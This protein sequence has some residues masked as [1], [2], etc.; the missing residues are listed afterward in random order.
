V[1]ISMAAID[2]LLTNE[3]HILHGAVETNRQVHWEILQRQGDLMA[4][5]SD[6]GL[7]EA[8]ALHEAARK[9][10]QADLI[11]A[12]HALVNTLSELMKTR[13]VTR[14]KQVRAL[15]NCW[16]AL[17]DA[18]FNWRLNSKLQSVNQWNSALKFGKLSKGLTAG[19]GLAGVTM[20]LVAGFA[21]PSPE[22]IMLE[23]IGKVKQMIFELGND[24]HGRFD[25]VD[26]SLNSIQTTLNETLNLVNEV[27][28]DVRQARQGLLEVQLDLHRLERQLFTSFTEQQRHNLKL[29][30]NSALYYENFNPSPMDWTDYSQSPNYEN[31]FYTYAT[32]FAANSISSPSSFLADDLADPNLQQQ[33]AARPLSANLNYLKAV[34]YSRTGQAVFGPQQPVLPNPQD[35]FVSAHTYLQLALENPGHFRNKGMRLPPLIAR[36]QELRNFFR[37]LTLG[38]S[39]TSVNRDLY[40]AL[41]VHYVNKLGNFVNQ[42]HTTEQAYAD[43]HLDH[44]PV[45]TWRDWA[46]AAPRVTVAGTG[47]RPLPLSAQ[48]VT[49][50]A[51][52]GYHNLALT[53]DGTVVGWGDD[54]AGQMTIPADVTQVTALAAGLYHSLALRS[55]DQVIAWGANDYGEGRQPADA[56]N[57]LAIAAG[58]YHNLALREDGRVLGWGAGANEFLHTFP[59]YQQAVVPAGATNIT[60]IAAGGY[61]SLALRANGT[62]LPWGLNNEGQLNI[63]A[64]ATNVMA[65]AAGH[66]HNL[67]LKSNGTLVA[68]G[69]NL[70]G[71]TNVPPAATN[72]IAIA[73]AGWHCLALRG[74]GVVFGWGWTNSGQAVVPSGLRNVRSLAAGRFHSL[75]LKNDGTV[76]GWG[77]NTSG[78][79]APPG[80]LP[81]GAAALVALNQASVALKADGTLVG[82]GDNRRNQRT[83]PAAATNVVA[84]AAGQVHGLALK[85]DAR[86]VG[87]GQ[88]S[89]G[90][91]NVFLVADN[92]SKDSGAGGLEFV[93]ADIPSFIG[94]HYLRAVHA[95]TLAELDK[96]GTLNTKAV[97]LSGVKALLQAVLELGLPYTLE[98]DDVLRGFFYGTEGLPDRDAA[99]ELL[100][101]ETKRLAFTRNARPSVFEEVFW[102]RHTVFATRLNERLLDV[103]E[104]G[105]P[106]IPRLVDHTLRLLNLLRDAWMH[107]ANS[108]PP[109]LELWSVGGSPRLLLHGEPY[110]RY[111]LQYRDGL[112]VPGWNDAIT[113]WRNGQM[114]IAPSPSG[115]PQRFYRAVLPPAP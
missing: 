41:L 37:A 111:N 48:G 19:G 5:L 70:Y 68:W 49:S 62:V 51:A 12:A 93:R 11:V 64:S 40:D 61:H 21:F 28:Y 23:E 18:S 54:T 36:G 67:V 95:N 55:D 39:A 14:S 80:S 73:A 79:S 35:W 82:W 92:G 74:D 15:G 63:P 52:G 26:G 106:E 30:I 103:Q 32:D 90:E 100:S 10:P 113:N 13:D 29:A 27:A 2:S 65:I 101:A 16:T 42:V 91:L 99:K 3:I 24:M 69:N 33:F 9:D 75:A 89:R 78:Q 66:G 94:R 53:Q 22:Q 20:A 56:T 76:I 102:L 4:Y 87:W 31:T 109:A 45:A 72:I 17:S 46:A 115:G 96:A 60:A 86:I 104:T 85:A 110:T 59:H 38:N 50:L 105:Q 114:I 58:Y 98:R 108:P 71:S 44:F 57:V 25:R 84:I 107:P 43:V 97:E 8:M 112:G 83:I 6:P 81:G 1:E 34:L 77:Q 88:N 7:V 47:I